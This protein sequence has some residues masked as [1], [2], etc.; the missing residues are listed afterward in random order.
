[1]GL[2]AVGG[3]G[4][5]SVS[6]YTETLKYLGPLMSQV[7]IAAC[8]DFDERVWDLYRQ[9]ATQHEPIRPG[10]REYLVVRMMHIAELTSNA[11]RMNATWA[12]TPPA[13]SLLRDRY[14]QTVRFSW[15][16]RN[17]D[18]TEFQKYER[19]MFSKMNSLVRNMDPETRA[20]YQEL[21]GQPLPA[22]ATETPSKEER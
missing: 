9:L 15:L 16:V 18:Q 10:S 13:M 2:S 14:E 3:T 12:L 22:W 8:C 11:I 1:M 5:K 19:S 20:H 7:P 21:T 6:D 17:P 4:I